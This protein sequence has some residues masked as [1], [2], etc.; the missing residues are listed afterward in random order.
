L[1][2]DKSSLVSNPNSGNTSSKSGGRRKSAFAEEDEGYAYVEEGFRIRFA[3]GETIDFY[4][5]S[6]AEKEE[7]MQALSQVVGKKDGSHGSGGDRKGKWTE[8]VLRRERAD[9]GRPSTMSSAEVDVATKNDVWGKTT[10]VRDFTKP[11]PTPKKDL[12]PAKKP[13]ERQRPQTPPMNARRGH[14]ERGEVKSMIF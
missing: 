1:V 11:P 6:T 9:G 3:N 12:S 7:W 8:L 13:T 14:R 4:A 5:D 10:E 2:D